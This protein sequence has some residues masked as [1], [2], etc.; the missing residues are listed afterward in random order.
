M[1][2][3]S[4]DNRSKIYDLRQVIGGADASR[5]ESVQDSSFEGL[6]RVVSQLETGMNQNRLS[7]DS[8]R[9]IVQALKVRTTEL[10]RSLRLVADREKE[11]FQRLKDAQAESQKATGKI[12][13]LQNEILSSKRTFQEFQ[14]KNIKAAQKYEYVLNL[15]R[16]Q[17]AKVQELTKAL[18]QARNESQKVLLEQAFRKTESESSTQETFS[19]LNKYSIELERMKSLVAG[20]D[21]HIRELRA[22]LSQ[23]IQKERNTMTQL[24][25][26]SGETSTTLS[27]TEKRLQVT[28]QAF[29]QERKLRVLAQE[30]MEKLEEALREQEKK[31]LESED[32]KARLEQSTARSIRLEAILSQQSRE[33]EQLRQL[34]ESL[35]ST[36][37]SEK[38]KQ[39]KTEADLQKKLEVA[40][41]KALEG[42]LA[43]SKGNS[44]V[45]EYSD[46]KS[47]L[48]QAKSQ[49]QKDRAQLEAKIRSLEVEKLTQTEKQT[50]PEVSD[51]SI[52]L[53]INLDFIGR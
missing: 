5:N 24:Q 15:Y 3:H 14:L 47:E 36:F 28:L 7:F 43:Q 50:Q 32:Q 37:S 46:L 16:R 44:A 41:K 40:K 8:L 51:S 48:E 53:G 4:N 19:K 29:H 21:A 2:S 17:E 12:D 42:K 31:S 18:E 34:N 1:D 27:E 33:I 13:D 6:D 30:R 11:L 38:E 10:E 20:R 9:T 25:K 35:K 22:V 26:L 52:D 45:Q 39:A 23:S 49:L